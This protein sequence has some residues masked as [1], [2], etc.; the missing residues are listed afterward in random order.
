MR[1]LQLSDFHLRGDGALSYRVTDT[2][3]C[4]DELVRHLEAM[5]P[6]PD[7][8]VLTG[9][10]A[11]SGD[12]LA[13]ELLRAALEPLCPRIYALPGNHDRRDRMRALLGPWCAP[14]PEIPEFLCQ[15][16]EDLP[17]RLL[18]FDTMS[19]GSHSGH[20]PPAAARWLAAKLRERPEVPAMVFMHHPPFK[21]GMGAMDEPFENVAELGEILGRAPWATLACGHMHRPIFTLFAGRLAM[22]APAVAMQLE[23]DLSPEGGDT[24]R[25]E[26]SGYLLHHWDGVRLNTHV[27]QIPGTPGFD[28]PYPFVDKVNPTED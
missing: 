23:L 15:A 24:F 7:A 19:P 3:R 6:A 2:R 27:C 17:V 1:I 12:A 9:D 21:S 8:L 28:G 25:M 26:A 5:T 14:D 13:Y 4:L 10:L 18:L 22:T 11:D 16:V 20:C